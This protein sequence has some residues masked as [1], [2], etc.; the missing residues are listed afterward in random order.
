MNQT[1]SEIIEI[2]DMATMH[3]AQYQL[4]IE[5]RLG[6]I[7]ATTYPNRDWYIDAM[8]TQGV[9]SIKCASISM[10]YGI[11]IHLTHDMIDVEKAAKKGAGELLERF[12]LSRNQR[13]NGV[14]SMEL[15]RNIKGEVHGASKGEYVQ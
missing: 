5:R 14:D 8:P 15:K 1:T 12:F 7:L 9:V 3:H 10:E 4:E 2:A 6:R 13:T 11:V